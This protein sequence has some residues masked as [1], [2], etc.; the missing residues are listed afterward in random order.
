MKLTKFWIGVVIII[1]AGF[2]FTKSFDNEFYFFTTYVVLQG[3]VIAVAWNILGGFTGYVNFGSA[4]F[5]AVG[6][7]AVRLRSCGE[8]C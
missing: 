4:G 8:L 2:I 3:L 7:G 5:F 1:V 6:G